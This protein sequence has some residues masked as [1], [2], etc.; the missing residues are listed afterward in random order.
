M[1]MPWPTVLGGGVG[2]AGQGQK[3]GREFG[4]KSRNQK[5]DEN[6]ICLQEKN[7]HSSVK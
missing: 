5:E 1:Q 6:L 2:A 7:V 3:L 4:F